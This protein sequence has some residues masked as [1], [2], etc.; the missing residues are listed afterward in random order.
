[1]VPAAIGLA[2]TP[3]LLYKLMPPEVKQTPEAPAAA[4]EKLKAMG[5]MSRN[6][7]IMLGT[8]CF[9][10]VLWV[11][12]H[13]VHVLQILSLSCKTSLGKARF[14]DTDWGLAQCPHGKISPAQANVLGRVNVN[15]AIV[16]TCKALP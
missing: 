16:G 11:R 3:L 13:H 9:A 12:A 7:S 14:L 6:E 10:L 15:A 8:M 4:A 5:P 2:V 1:M